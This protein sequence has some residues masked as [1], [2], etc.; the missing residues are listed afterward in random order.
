ME[1]LKISVRPSFVILCLIVI[2]CNNTFLFF[3]YVFSVL[4]HELAHY[5]VAKIYYFRCNTIVLS[6][7]GAV[8][9]GDFDESVGAQQ[10]NIA[11][12]GPLV[13]IALAMLFVALWY[14]FPSSY[15]Y[16]REFVYANIAIGA[17]NLL[18]CYPLDGGK[19][20]IGLLYN[21]F[22]YKKSLSITKKV[23]FVFSVTLFCVFAVSLFT[24]Y[25]LFA[26][27]LMAVFLF[28][29]A[30]MSVDKK[31]YSRLSAFDNAEKLLR[32]GMERRTL[33][34]LSTATLDMA[35][36]K[37]ENGYLTRI[38][39]VDKNFRLLKTI[40]A[41]DFNNIILRYPLNTT[42]ESLI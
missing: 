21:K 42:F 19:V 12:S 33:V 31:I 14:I 7:T 2:L 4:I 1:R 32:R 38:E 23:T 13:N 28:G 36:K 40:E 29:G 18:P 17:T 20:L 37:R 3:S 39:I 35:V 24:P 5:Y 30:I 27:G 41:Q 22:G 15:V 26:L 8:L 9:Y 25:P 10:C 11:L 16:T 34:F 6:F